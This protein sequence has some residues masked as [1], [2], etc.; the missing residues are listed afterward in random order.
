MPTAQLHSIIRDFAAL[1]AT[2]RELLQAL[3]SF[4]KRHF[5]ATAVVSTLV[6]GQLR[7][8]ASTDDRFE[9]GELLDTQ[10]E[11]LRTLEQG[12]ANL[13]LE[14]GG[15]QGLNWLSTWPVKER[16]GTIGVLQLLSERPLG[17]AAVLTFRIF[18]DLISSRLTDTS[19]ARQAHAVAELVTTLGGAGSV[20]EAAEQALELVTRFMDAQAGYLLQAVGGVMTPLAN[21]GFEADAER[22]TRLGINQHHPHG[23]AWQACIE[24]RALLLP[25]SGDELQPL[26]RPLTLV[27]PL[28]WRNHYRYALVLRLRPR[29]VLS[30]ADEDAFNALCTQLHLGLERLQTDRLQDRLLELQALVV[31]SDA[32]GVYQQLVDEAVRLVPGA[33]AGSLLVRSSSTEP[34]T[35]RAA[36]GFDMEPLRSVRLSEAN[37]Q[38]WYGMDRDAWDA[39]TIRELRASETDIDQASQLS[40]GLD[41]Q[42]VTGTEQIRASLCLPVSYRG[43]VLA[44]LNL[45]N[46]YDT[47]AFGEDSVR[48][49][50]MFTPVMASMLGALREWEN[51]I[52]AAHTD[53][54]TGL[55][56]RRGFDLALETQLKRAERDGRPFALIALDLR[57]FKLVNDT[58]GHKAGDEALTEVAGI[59]LDNAREG[60]TV[61][62]WGGDEFS[63]LLPGAGNDVAGEVANRI[64]AAVAAV[65]FRGIGLDVHVGVACYPEDARSAV[66]LLQIAD[67]RMYVSK[68]GS[69]RAG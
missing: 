29:D 39:G 67:Q 53:A 14:D 41:G 40:A 56:N 3:P 47:Y 44:F 26:T 59:M 31:D 66:E 54:L 35:F 28:G 15:D 5:R 45:D 60:D 51:M 4:L 33:S 50:K 19:R 13:Q 2:R 16:Q 18:V 32:S 25:I 1:P 52:Q 34:F 36:H 49:L 21:C 6:N 24:Q 65:A 30:A 12:Q 57:N 46:L 68:P 27:Q 63:V 22:S 42:L 10:S 20:Q 17:E 58:H 7:V 62:R 23:L 55:P 8:A 64:R 43:D 37:M 61:S 9:T 69:R 11:T 48:A 38:S